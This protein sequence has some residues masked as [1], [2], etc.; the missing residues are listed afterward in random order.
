VAYWREE[1]LE[2]DGVLDGSRGSWAIE[3]KTG[4]FGA[5]DVRGLLEF[6]AR[7]PKYK[8][9]LLCDSSELAAAARLGVPAIGW[10]RFLLEGP[11]AA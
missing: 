6:T 5:A 8:P 7:F 10:K 4:A 11:D 3:V 2:V 9:L 1:P